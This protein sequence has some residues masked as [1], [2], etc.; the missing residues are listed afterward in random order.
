MPES[1]LCSV[2]NSA[3]AALM[4][5]P[6]AVLEKPF[7]FAR[8]AF[9][10]NDSVSVMVSADDRAGVGTMPNG[11]SSC[12]FGEGSKVVFSSAILASGAV[13]NQTLGFRVTRDYQTKKVSE[14]VYRERNKD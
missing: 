6:P 7:G 14:L 1:S 4:L 2:A 11:D 8:R 3:S 12:A 9:S 5:T 10:R 13:A